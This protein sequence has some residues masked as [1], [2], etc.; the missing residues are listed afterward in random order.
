LRIILC[1]CLAGGNAKNSQAASGRLFERFKISTGRPSCQSVH[2][3][4]SPSDAG[5]LARP[6]IRRKSAGNRRLLPDP[7]GRKLDD[8]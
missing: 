5:P 4:I 3:A 2:P 1:A 7:E 6:S 8:R